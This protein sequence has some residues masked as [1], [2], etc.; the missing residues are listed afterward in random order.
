[1]N[2]RNWFLRILIP[3]LIL[4]AGTIEAQES[5]SP[6]KIKVS[7]VR[8]RAGN[9]YFVD[10]PNFEFHVM[11]QKSFE[12][13]R[14][15]VAADYDYTRK[16]M[17]FGMSHSLHR[18]AV[19]P[20]VSVGDNLYFR[21]IYKDSKLFSSDSTGVWYRKQSVT[22]YLY[23]EL[24]KT[25]MLMM[26]FQF[27]KEW[28]PN[29]RIGTEFVSYYDYSVRLNYLRFTDA[30]GDSLGDLFLSMSIERSYKVF[31][32]QY[33]YLIFETFYQLAHD[34]GTY[35]NY[36]GNYGFQGNITPQKSPLFFIGGNTTLIGYEND[37]F[38]GRRVFYAQNRFSFRPFPDFQ[39]ISKIMKFRKPSLLCQVDFGRVRGASSYRGLK[40]QRGDL[41]IGAGLG[42]GFNTDLPYIP[43]TDLH[44]IIACPVDKLTDI[45]YYAG[46]GSQL[47]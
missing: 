44:I 11:L 17:G 43:K 16:D 32:G 9:S 5:E 28:S 8:F 45:K 25:T 14:S 27:E 29:R 26:E 21:R 22:P 47:Q 36:L 35:T 18:Y 2:I 20:G 12:N 46:F 23:H 31:K 42:L 33:N 34:F 1:M 3:V 4:T 6:V 15:S 24:T 7:R 41:R 39:L 19:N 38:W 13:I 30:G 10:I 40:P 37:E